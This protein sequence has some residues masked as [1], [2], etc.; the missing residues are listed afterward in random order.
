MAKNCYLCAREWGLARRVDECWLA[1][2]AKGES[3]Y[4]NQQNCT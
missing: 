2:P 3:K 4:L 1:T